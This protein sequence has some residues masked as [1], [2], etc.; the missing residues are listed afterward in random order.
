MAPGLAPGVST[1][2]HDRIISIAAAAEAQAAAAHS[3]AVISDEYGYP[4]PNPG[5]WVLEYPL[6]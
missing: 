3:E 4:K 6:S 1:A 2:D 5:F